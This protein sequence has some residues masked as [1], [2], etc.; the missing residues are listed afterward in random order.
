MHDTLA[1]VGSKSHGNVYP[2]QVVDDPELVVQEPCPDEDREVRGDRERHHE[3]RALEPLQLQ[4]G[5]VQRDRE[6][7]AERKRER[8][9]RDPRRRMSR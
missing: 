8:R 1:Q 6:E 9:P 7:E 3:Q 5:L 2:E 4:V